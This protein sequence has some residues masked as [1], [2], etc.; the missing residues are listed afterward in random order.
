MNKE[1]EIQTLRMEKLDTDYLE[2]RLEYKRFLEELVSKYNDYD[3]KVNNCY[4]SNEDIYFNFITYHYDKIKDYITNFLGSNILG[5]IERVNCIN[6]DFPEGNE[7]IIKFNSK[8]TN[9]D[10][11]MAIWSEVQ[12]LEYYTKTV[13][14]VREDYLSFIKREEEKYKPLLSRE[15]YCYYVH[16][17]FYFNQNYMG[18]IPQNIMY[19]IIK[20]LEKN[21]Y[22]KD[23][24]GQYDRENYVKGLNE[25]GLSKEFVK[26]IT[27]YSPE[28]LED[29]YSK[30]EKTR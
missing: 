8:C 29:F 28:M 17:I 5:K 23:K 7:I 24:N 11:L 10:L 18:Y 20:M 15:A 6:N 3:H 19:R 1:K 4:L 27:G 12:M 2:A 30:I 13:E 25:L 14:E 26:N 22:F 21:Y 16:N 9:K